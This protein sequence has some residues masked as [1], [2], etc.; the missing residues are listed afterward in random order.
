[1]NKTRRQLEQAAIELDVQLE[2]ELG[3]RRN[4]Y[5]NSQNHLAMTFSSGKVSSELHYIDLW[6][7]PWFDTTASIYGEAYEYLQAL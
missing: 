7:E 3:A 2:I 6:W 5:D 1:M 4:S